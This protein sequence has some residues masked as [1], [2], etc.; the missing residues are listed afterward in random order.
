MSEQ[1]V[2]ATSFNRAG[3]AVIAATVA[4]LV[5]TVA[6]IAFWNRGLDRWL[7]NNFI[8]IGGPFELI[9]QN[10]ASFRREQLLGRPHIIYF[11]FT[12][13][14]DLCPTTLYQIAGVI[15]TLK[16]DGDDLSVAFISV[17]PE[18]DT[19]NVIREYVAA[20]SEDFI[21]LTGSPD[22]IATA[23][24]AYHVY[25]QKVDLDGGDYTIDHKASAMLFN[26]DGSYLSAILHDDSDAEARRKIDRLLAGA[27]KDPTGDQGV[28]SSSR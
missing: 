24:K 17:D 22:A 20:F 25:Y 28:I 18:R 26:A 15:E 12:Y 3:K 6:T 5:L 13:C 14:P 21:G 7:A 27:N 8:G 11:G 2:E 10:G 19:V 16:I 4:L 9:D 1:P 23:A